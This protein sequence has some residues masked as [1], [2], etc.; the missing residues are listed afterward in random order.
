VRGAATMGDVASLAGVSHQTVSRV[1]NVPETVRPE[2]RDRVLGAIERLGYR[3]NVAARALVT[4]R[5]Q[6]IG[7]VS[8]GTRL[9]GPTSVVFGIEQAA[10]AAGYYV[11]IASQQ[12]VDAVTLAAALQRLSEHGVEGVVVIAPQRRAQEALA[13]L[14]R[15]LPAVVVDGHDEGLA[16]RVYVDH[17]KGAR[18][19][20]AHLLAQGV[21]SVHHLAGPAGWLETQERELGWRRALEEAGRSAPE[22][23]VGDWSCAAGYAAGLRLAADPEVEA[24]FAANDQMALGLLCALAEG[25]R[26][27]PGDV[28][29]AG[30][31]DVPEAEFFR[32]PL[33][34]VRQDFAT[35]GRRSIDLLVA[36]IEGET[37]PSSVAVPA[38]LVVRTSSTRVPVRTAPTTPHP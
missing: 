20:V 36:Q 21:R 16:P 23:L 32:P 31:D 34:T 17:R 7:V 35:L 18:D 3:R 26:T 37:V 19:V 27:V 2:T 12:T 13:R 38:E 24:V 1:L 11:S 6:T 4:R 8:L 15:D 10:R 28:L 22:P 30:F 33:T 14:A 29:V 5:S 25:G 9:F